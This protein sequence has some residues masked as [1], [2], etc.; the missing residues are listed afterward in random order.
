MESGVWNSIPNLGFTSKNG[1][2][3]KL[4]F[5]PNPHVNNWHTWE[6]IYH[7]KGYVVDVLVCK[8]AYFEM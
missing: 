8:F 4:V 3:K 2:T 5:N 7:S 1:R 6:N